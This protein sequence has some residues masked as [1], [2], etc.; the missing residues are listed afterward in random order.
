MYKPGDDARPVCLVTDVPPAG[1]PAGVQAVQEAIRTDLWQRLEGALSTLNKCDEPDDG[2]PAIELRPGAGA[3][4]QAFTLTDLAVRLLPQQRSVLTIP[5][6]E[7]VATGTPDVPRNAETCFAVQT[8]ADIIALS[9]HPGAGA[10][11][12]DAIAPLITRRPRMADTL[13]LFTDR[14]AEVALA[15]P[16]ENHTW[17]FLEDRA[18]CRVRI[19]ADGHESRGGIVSAMFQQSTSDQFLT[20]LGEIGDAVFLDSRQLLAGRQG[21]CQSDFYHS[22]L[23]DAS[24]VKDPLLKR[25]TKVAARSKKPLILGGPSVVNG[26]LYVL[27]DAAWRQNENPD[28]GYNVKW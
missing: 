14:D 15:G 6:A 8:G 4:L 11:V 1:L 7:H 12:R 2:A 23:G 19:F 27:I 9:L 18:A 24:S 28:R 25:L 26:I 13:E 20:W 16:I 17:R 10:G 21:P 22:D 5:L 3:L